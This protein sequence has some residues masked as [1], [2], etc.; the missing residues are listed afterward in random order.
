MDEHKLLSGSGGEDEKTIAYEELKGRVFGELDPVDPHNTIITDIRLADRDK[1]GLVAYTATFTLLKPV[2][3]SRAS[4]VLSYE[5]PNRGHFFYQ[6][7]HPGDDAKAGYIILTSGWQGD[8]KSGADLQTISVPLAHNPDGSSLT[9]L[10]LV[11]LYNLP[12]NSTTASLATGYGGL[13]Y[14]HPADLNS[15]NASLVRQSSERAS[16]TAIDRRD[17]AFADCTN[18]P[19]PGIPDRTKI[20]L[21]SGF[22]SQSL[23]QLVFTAKDPLVLGIGFAATRDIVSFFRYAKHD[24]T[25]TA[26][27]IAGIISHA[28]GFGTSQS[29]NFI[30]TFIHLG[31]NQDESNRIVWDGANPNI[32]ARQNPMNFRFAIPGGAANL[33]E[34]GSEAVLW[35]SDYQDIRR[36]RGTA[37][38]LDRCRSTQTCP[39]IMETFGSSEF[40]GLRMS[41]GLVGTNADTDIPLPPNVRRYYFPGTTHGGGK[42]GFS[43]APEK[44]AA[45]SLPANPNPSFDTMRALRRALIAWAV[46][47][48]APPPSQYPRLD[49]GQ[50]V[51]P[52]HQAM[53]F[54]EIPGYPLPDS[55]INPFF[56]YDFGPKFDY[57]DLSGV[58]SIQP[59]II[60]QVLPMLVPKVD[61]DGNE[62]G[63]VPSVLHHV[64]LGTYLGWN[65]S[66]SGFYKNESCGFT[67]GFIPFAKTRAERLASGDPRLSLEERYGTHEQYVDRVRAAA[68]KLIS[69]G[70]LVKEDGDRL[71]AEAEASDVLH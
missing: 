63:G 51:P 54:P 7:D 40:W 61:A 28:I 1:R 53:G 24:D 43:I 69:E 44:A 46:E 49:R 68:R 66:V 31:F 47:N 67:G 60:R 21:K 12:S 56:D 45:C 11:R 20:C 62:T 13:A 41:P 19:F 15:A 26:N 27:P 59:P 16:F 52:Q 71:I 17:W 3:L 5:V 4:G 37:G 29:G 70:F 34:P 25:G 64:P 9:G 33:Y 2:A 14:Q 30:K 42:G 8:L 35:W 38:M 18:R 23:Y 50:L 57:A 36:N 55:L 6:L 39:K 10:V 58:I 32:A 22:D 65:V 48:K